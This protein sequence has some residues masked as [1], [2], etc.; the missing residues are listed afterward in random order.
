MVNC[1]GRDLY[2]WMH[3]A[4]EIRNLPTGSDLSLSHVLSAVDVETD[5][6]A[7]GNIQ[8]DILDS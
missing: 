8:K 5:A 7:R 6:L 2:Q 1:Q 3:M 4:S